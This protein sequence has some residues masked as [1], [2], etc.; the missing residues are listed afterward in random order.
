MI[1]REPDA[2]RPAP[3]FFVS[4]AHTRSSQLI[5]SFFDDLSGHVQE[6][7]GRAP[8]DDPGFLDRSMA[9]GRRW[10]PELL[11]AVSTC[12]VFVPLL[13][14]SLF[15]SAWCGYEWHAFSQRRVVNRRTGQTDMETAIVPVI[16]VPHG[17]KPEPPV[18]GQIQKFSPTG[19]PDEVVKKY[20]DDGI[21][22]L[23]FVDTNA[24]RA[25]VW[26]LAQRV[27]NLHLSHHVERGPIPDENQLRNA[28]TE[29]SG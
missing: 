24:Y 15:D 2:D 6:L 23:S 10:A 18:I 12:Q 9:G 5:A 29:E 16:W 14:A 20:H 25:V 22:G 13:S 3:I 8:G 1:N 17:T 4:Y 11:H 28:F 26:K 7:V 19:L 21:Y 27:V